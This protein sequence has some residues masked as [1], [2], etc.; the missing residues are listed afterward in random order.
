MVQGWKVDGCATI[1][2]IIVEI[3]LTR[4]F[5]RT[6]LTLCLD[7]VNKDSINGWLFSTRLNNLSI[8]V[9]YRGLLVGKSV[10]TIYREDVC[11][12]LKVDGTHGFSISLN[13]Y[14]PKNK[15]YSKY[16]LIVVIHSGNRQVLRKPLQMI[17][18]PSGAWQWKGNINKMASD[19][20]EISFNV[21]SVSNFLIQGWAISR[22][23][24][25]RIEVGLYANGK[26]ISCTLANLYRKDLHIQK[27]GDGWHSFLLDAKCLRTCCAEQAGASLVLR[28]RSC[29]GAEKS[30]ELTPQEVTSL[31]D[32]LGDSTG[33]RNISIYDRS[34]RTMLSGKMVVPISDEIASGTTPEDCQLCL[35]LDSLI[36]STGV[37]ITCT[38]NGVYGAKS[39]SDN[40]SPIIESSASS[41]ILLRIET[42]PSVSIDDYRF[43]L[44]SSAGIGG[45]AEGMRAFAY[46]SYTSFFKIPQIMLQ[47]NSTLCLTCFTHIE[48]RK[49]N[50]PRFSFV[51]VGVPKSATTSLFH[52][53]DRH[54]EIEMA[55]GKEAHFFSEGSDY[56]QL[57]V[58]KFL[59]KGGKPRNL[60]GHLYGE[61]TP[62]YFG[63]PGC[64]ERIALI[65]GRDTRII[66]S[67][68]NPL[69]R[70]FSHYNHHMRELGIVEDGRL[71]GVRKNEVMS[72]MHFL[73]YNIHGNVQHS[74]YYSSMCR[75]YSLFGRENV[76]VLLQED[77]IG[78]G[79][80]HT[81]RLV[82]GFIGA[83]ISDDV[84]EIAVNKASNLL[85]DYEEVSNSRTVSLRVW[86]RASSR[87]N[88]FDKNANIGD[89][90]VR[91]CRSSEIGLESF[92]VDN[93]QTE[94]KND[95][96]Y[97]INCARSGAQP[98]DSH[99]KELAGV[100]FNDDIHK[101]SGLL[102]RDLST[103]WNK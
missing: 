62:N 37:Y 103:C 4:L 61:F 95:C 19:Q 23:S 90:I 65:N 30:I 63:N 64:L 1:L 5:G 88:V 16:K 83:T 59:T 43:T 52:H 18:D 14:L 13:E 51:G 47:K 36:G 76:F 35:E 6:D 24:S 12:K 9:Y 33:S 60:K 89:M 21:D 27:I 42:S 71:I 84:P 79:F 93:S 82:E 38:D 94:L 81:V 102:D 58:D 46:D 66:V 91:F 2:L 57:W 67:L 99:V 44:S 78:A 15:N 48:S 3:V 97:W 56:D 7:T 22:R 75:A 25:E 20:E 17:Q 72:F 39:S 10:C 28:F 92:L 69:R 68:R 40:D 11:R 96:R 41:D 73:E 70:S 26:R 34:V 45:Y 85:P 77:L 29:D 74:Q 49:L 87:I 98:D 32:S 8:S 54:P 50:R 53:L 55:N 31:T 86:D 80:A 101:L 100:L